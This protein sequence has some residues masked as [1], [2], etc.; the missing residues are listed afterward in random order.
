MGHCFNNSDSIQ[1]SFKSSIYNHIFQ[2]KQGTTRLDMLQEDELRTVVDDKYLR[3]IMQSRNEMG[4]SLNYMLSSTDQTYVGHVTIIIIDGK[5]LIAK[6]GVSG[7]VN[8]KITFVVS[9]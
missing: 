6:I 7:G 8:I 1:N 9:L 3:I 2:T 4:N 5:I